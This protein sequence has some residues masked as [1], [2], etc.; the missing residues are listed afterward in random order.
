MKEHVAGPAS[1]SPDGKQI[2]VIQ[3]NPALRRDELYVSAVDGSNNQLIAARVYPDHFSW[4]ST[5]AWSNDG[6]RIL[7]AI[8]GSDAQGFYSY[9]M[10]V[11]LRDRSMRIL[12]KP[13]WQYIE[14]AT[15]TGDGHGVLIIAREPDL[16][17]L[18]L[19]FLPFPS[20]PPRRLVNDL[21]DYSGLT[22]TADTKA[23]VSV[24]FQTLANV[25]VVTASNL[26]RAIQITPG[27][28]RYFDLRWT[29]QGKLLYSSDASGAAEIWTMNADGTGQ[30]ELTSGPGRSYAPNSSP[31]GSAIIF[32]SNRTGSWNIWKM[33]ADGNR[34]QQLTFGPQDSNWPQ[35]SPDGNSIVYHHTGA[36]ATWNLWRV[37]LSGG[38]P[39]QLTS[40][41][42]VMPDVSPRDGSIAC[43][44]SEDA[45]KPRCQ[46]A[47]L[48][49]GGGQPI[50]TFAVS[51]TAA[52]DSAIR[53]T[54]DGKGITFIDNFGGIGNI[55]LQPVDGGA[56]RPLTHFTSGQIYSFDWSK[57]G[58]LAYSRG[59]S[60]S[61]V[62]LAR[63]IH[64]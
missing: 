61:D 21:S 36:E 44:F 62:V 52:T 6:T 46:L 28:G 27:S 24:Q 43:W 41:L 38:K 53:W 30:R 34:L 55:G 17:F 54:P 13:R 31:S 50:R 1:V 60:T 15:W 10:A 32:H 11:T 29:P 20:G 5:P 23:L 51:T 18:H 4:P 26:D 7:C 39:E 9:P 25:Y 49:P 64:R 45:A 48:R 16:A 3:A 35:F 63:E 19:W 56:S 2:A 8:E 14:Q 40:Q 12:K 58:R 33:D 22:V 59:L 42:S 37:P 57:D 47:V